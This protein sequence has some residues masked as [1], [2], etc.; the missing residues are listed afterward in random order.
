MALM[1]WPNYVGRGRFI[2]SDP[3]LSVDC[4]GIQGTII[5]TLEPVGCGFR[6][7]VDCLVERTTGVCDAM[8]VSLDMSSGGDCGGEGSVVLECRESGYRCFNLSS[9]RTLGHINVVARFARLSLGSEPCTSVL[10]PSLHLPVTILQC[11]IV[12]IFLQ[13]VLCCL[14]CFTQL[15][16]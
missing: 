7:E 12:L 6:L 16:W 9:P 5:P 2:V 10:P 3:V 1:Y 14:R 8:V 11:S 13:V 15:S 4:T